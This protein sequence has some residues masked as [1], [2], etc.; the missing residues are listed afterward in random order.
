M[1]HAKKAV[2]ICSPVLKSICW[3]NRFETCWDTFSMETA[4]AQTAILLCQLSNHNHSF[5][6]FSVSWKPHSTW[7][8][9]LEC[10]STEAQNITYSYVRCG[11]CSPFLSFMYYFN[12]KWPR[13]GEIPV[14]Q[15]GKKKPK[16][17]RFWS[18]EFTDGTGDERETQQHLI[19]FYLAFLVIIQ[20]PELE[21]TQRDHWI[22]SPGTA[23]GKPKSH[24]RWLKVVQK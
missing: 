23:Q 14:S 9:F 21:G 11:D 8:L 24:P 22:P 12:D 15:R 7:H 2:P 16:Q 10:R 19:Y 5:L 13:I 6:L 17:N 1:G 18:L 4:S 20:C 3:T